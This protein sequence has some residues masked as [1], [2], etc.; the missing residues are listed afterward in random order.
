MSIT[1]VTAETEAKAKALGVSAEFV[2]VQANGE[3][4]RHVAEMVDAG[5]LAVTVAQTFSLDDVTTAFDISAQGR[6]RG[7]LVMKI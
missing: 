4:L 3:Q 2:F 1:G 7:K 6:V 5:Q